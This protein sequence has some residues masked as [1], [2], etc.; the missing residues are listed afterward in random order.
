M[1]GW[2]D[3]YMCIRGRGGGKTR[4]ARTHTHTDKHIHI[5]MLKER[6]KDRKETKTPPHPLEGLGVDD[7][8][9]QPHKDGGR[10]RQALQVVLYGDL[11]F[12]GVLFCFVLG[13]EFGGRGGGRCE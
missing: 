8:V 4:H 7:R 3:A 5:C 12:C 2:V 13:V 6:K 9:L 10:H 1:D 11:F